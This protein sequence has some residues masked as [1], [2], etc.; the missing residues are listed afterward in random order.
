MRIILLF[1]RLQLGGHR[2]YLIYAF[3]AQ[4]GFL[5]PALIAEIGQGSHL[6][7]SGRNLWSE[8]QVMDSCQASRNRQPGTAGQPGERSIRKCGLKGIHAGLCRQRIK[9]D[10]GNENPEAAI[11]GTSPE[12]GLL[13]LILAGAGSN[14][15]RSDQQSYESQCYNKVVHK[16]I[17]L[18]GDRMR[19][20]HTDHAPAGGNSVYHFDDLSV[21]HW[22]LKVP[23]WLQFPLS[24]ILFC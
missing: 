8:S 20:P 4:R 16:F 15:S 10:W 19:Y 13:S 1:E 7:K 2:S 23:P 17:L 9:A 24:P 3:A 21:L 6:R 5:R 18:A 14:D 12:A 11:D 22:L